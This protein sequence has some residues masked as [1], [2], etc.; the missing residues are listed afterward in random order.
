MK[1]LLKL[2]D[3]ALLDANECHLRY[4]EFRH[5]LNVISSFEHEVKLTY[6]EIECF[7]NQLFSA[8][9]ARELQYKYKQS[10]S[11]KIVRPYACVMVCPIEPSLN[12]LS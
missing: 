12:P 1:T 10:F 8:Q 4:C 9:A 6:H 3:V 5:S 7:Y 11:R 2:F